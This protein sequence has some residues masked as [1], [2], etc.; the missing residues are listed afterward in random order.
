MNE[1]I[2]TIRKVRKEIQASRDSS[3]VFPGERELCR[4]ML[5][6]LDKIASLIQSY[7]LQ[8]GTDVH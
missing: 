2:A 4:N 1:V 7:S 6:D 5:A 8:H 3:E